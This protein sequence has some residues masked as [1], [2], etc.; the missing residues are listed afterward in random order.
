MEFPINP[1]L[2]KCIDRIENNNILDKMAISFS[3][4]PVRYIDEGLFASIPDNY[5]LQSYVASFDLDWTLTFGQK[6]LFPSDEDDIQLIPGRL[7]YLNGL[8]KMGYTIVIFTNQ[9]RNKETTTVKRLQHLLKSINIPVLVYAATKKKGQYRKPEIGMYQQLRN[10]Y[11][12]RKQSINYM[13]Y[14]GDAA[15]RVGDFSD[16]DA[17]FAQN[18]DITFYTPEEVFP[19]FPPPPQKD[20]PE[21]VIF[22]GAPGTG[23]STAYEKYYSN[24]AHIEQDALKTRTKVL[25]E[26]KRNIAQG[27]SMVID[28]TNPDKREEYYQLG[29]DNGYSITVLYFIRDGVA[30]DK[31][32]QAAGGRHVP[33]VVWHMFYKKLVVPTVENVPGTLHYVVGTDYND[34]SSTELMY[35]RLASIYN[36]DDVSALKKFIDEY[37][38]DVNSSEDLEQI[39]EYHPALPLLQNAIMQDCVNIVEYLLSRPDIELGA[40]LPLAV[41]SDPKIVKMLLDHPDIDIEILDEVESLPASELA[42]TGRC[43]E[44]MKLLVDAGANLYWDSIEHHDRKNHLTGAMRKYLDTLPRD[45][46]IYDSED[47]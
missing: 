25:K 38:W 33:H 36:N 41:G 6:K 43:V 40:S 35:Q 8:F 37:K 1:T 13:F 10:L 27:N 2:K 11:Q 29:L 34:K 16:S 17:K 18:C 5:R 4:S 14:V 31:R 9:A 32:R 46:F 22:V 21:M 7:E 47:V 45:R 23:K 42:L 24:Y 28:A 12:E 26:V 15:G 39:G 44:T 30:G 19:F 3:N 20:G